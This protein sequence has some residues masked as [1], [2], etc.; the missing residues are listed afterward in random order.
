MIDDEKLDE[1]LQ[2]CKRLDENVK[3]ADRI[4]PS[5]VIEVITRLRQ[6]EKD[7]ERYRW[8]KERGRHDY[9]VDD[10]FDGSCDRIDAKVDEAMQCK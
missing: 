10:F 9:D 5:V 1:L 4:I 2:Y 7:A 8:I 6:A 3:L